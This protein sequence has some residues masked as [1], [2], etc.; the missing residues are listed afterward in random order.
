MNEIA[1]EHIG[2]FSPEYDENRPGDVHIYLVTSMAD[3]SPRLSYHW[4]VE[5]DEIG[6]IGDEHRSVMQTLSSAK[7]H[8]ADEE[9]LVWDFD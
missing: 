8:F 6:V 7:K 4:A 2:C 1:R 5:D 3:E 9:N